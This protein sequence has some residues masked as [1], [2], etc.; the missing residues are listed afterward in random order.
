MKNISNFL[1]IVQ[2]RQNSVRFPNK[3]I[4]KV[5]G[6]PLIYFLINR[7][8]LANFKKKI[9]I[10]IPKGKENFILKK[11]LLKNNYNVF[12][13]SE[14]NVLE[15]YYKCAKKYN[16][17]NIIRITSDCPLVD[18]KLLEKLVSIYNKKRIDYLNNANPP[19][20]PDGLDIEIFNFK[21]L[22]MAYLNAKD[23][24]EKE[25]VT[26]YIKKNHNLKKYNFKNIKDLSNWRFTLDYKEDLVVIKKII[27][28]FYPRIDFTFEEIY[29]FV[30]KHKK[31]LKINDKYMRN[32]GSISDSNYKMWQRAK[33]IIPGGN[34]LISKRPELFIPY[35]WP[36]YFKKAKNITITS[37]QNIKYKDFCSMGIG[38]NILGYSNNL[39][40][41]N[42][43]KIVEDGNMSTLNSFEDILLAEKLIE[44]H[45]W[46]DMAKFLRSGGEANALAI[47]ISRAASKK[48]K[49]AI[50]GYHGW[51][52]WYLS[53]NLGNKS[54]LDNHLMKSLDP[55]GVP[56]NLKN[57]VFPFKYNDLNSL[58][59]ILKNHDIGTIKME[60]TR[61]IKPKKDYLKKIRNICDKKKIILIFDECTSGFRNSFGGIHK[62]YN[63][64]PDIAMFGKALGNGYPIT[65]VIGRKEIMECAN[66]S[67]ISSTMW[68]D[69]IG[70]TAA[71]ASLDQMEKLKSWQYI[72]N[73]GIWLKEKWKKLAKKHK[74]KIEIQGMDA[75]PNF[76]FSAKKHAQYKTLITQE[77]LNKKILATNKIFISTKHSK[78]NLEIY[79]EYLDDIFYKINKIENGED[80]NKYLKSKVSYNPYL[81]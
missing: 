63:I 14:K 48:D 2:A 19:S 42:V 35:K 25:H 68:T 30:I 15:R 33:N 77:M 62:T 46:A 44:I 29:K 32:S 54:N 27:E 34:M 69:R 31:I 75:I 72:S 16:A 8:S 66:S 11:L 4:K 17:K 43:K 26:P 52:D 41:K 39:V 80:L 3:I 13:G 7:L 58:N 79:L 36:T 53:A 21:S 76:I 22:K 6:Y 71:L 60:V 55:L 81:K 20:F 74:L 38:T 18:P 24:H 12:S 45:P 1:I 64:N 70:P 51:H 57:T 78:E 5:C 40:D 56:K 67:F 50:C 59:H 23:R 9:V 10:A 65:A 28:N 61:E 49:V 47:R 73:L 37:L